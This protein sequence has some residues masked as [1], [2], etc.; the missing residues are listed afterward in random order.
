LLTP[1]LAFKF[2]LNNS[3]IPMFLNIIPALIDLDAA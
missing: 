3:D 2:N 1:G